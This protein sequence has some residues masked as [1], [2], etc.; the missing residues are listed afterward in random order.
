MH[1]AQIT[2]RMLIQIVA[3]LRKKSRRCSMR[4][5][6]IFNGNIPV[7][8]HWLSVLTEKQINNVEG[9]FSAIS[10]I[11][12]LQFHPRR[13]IPPK[14]ANVSLFLCP[15]DTLYCPFQVQQRFTVIGVSRITDLVIVNQHTR[16]INRNSVTFA[17]REL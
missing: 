4:K 11:F 2:R 8:R 3:R 7:L 5:F 10:S 15:C 13:H 9:Q 14:T 17:N 16:R 6:P 1:G 12:P